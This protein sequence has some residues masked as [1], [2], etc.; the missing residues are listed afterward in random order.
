MPDHF[1]SKSAASNLL[2]FIVSTAGY[3]HS[4]HVAEAARIEHEFG[5]IADADPPRHNSRR[6][7]RVKPCAGMK[8]GGRR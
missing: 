2:K 5:E 7:S 4:E 3:Q 8:Q 6:L 1:C